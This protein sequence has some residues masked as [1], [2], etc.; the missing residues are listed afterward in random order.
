MFI[1]ILTLLSI[2]GLIAGILLLRTIP[3]GAA[4]LPTTSHRLSISVIIPARNEATNLP[5]LLESLRHAALVP[6]QI[7]IID[8]GSTD[9]T[10]A[11]ATQYGATVIASAPLPPGWTGKTW[12]CHQ[13]ALAATG[14]AFLFLDADTYF[15][16]HGY[17]RIVEHFVTLPPNA[18]LSVLPF[19]RTQLWYEELSLF[20]NILV[21][22]GAGGFGK[23]DTPHL[24]GQSMLIR[25]SLY[26]QAGGHQ[27]IKREILEN[28]HFAA[29][30]RIAN[31]IPFT[32]GGRNTLE[33]RM[34]PDGLAQLRE[35]WQ[36]AFA[37]GA[38]VTS[39]L[40]LA[41]SIYWLAA[42]MLTTI[43]LVAIHSPAI[44][45]L[46]ILNTIQI[47]WYARQLGTFRWTT[48]LLYPIPLYFYFATFAQSIWRRKRRQPV[49]WR[50]RQL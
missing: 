14:E 32:L 29:N 42:A 36:K 9:N 48:A 28:L 17:A 6:A 41:L 37:T 20:F 44:A 40:V 34:F 47:A 12:A 24:F 19:H 25:R 4:R 16:P 46:Y 31:G 15:A 1:L 45:A 49:T 22:M 50:G 3:I 11:I 5:P 2:G 7:L 33:M 10:A 26:E 43:L 18:A 39:P 13:G 23:L 8:D 30:I 38:S 27:S 21:A 35:S